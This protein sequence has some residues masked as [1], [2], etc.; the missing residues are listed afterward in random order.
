MIKE[1][2]HPLFWSLPPSLSATHLTSLALDLDHDSGEGERREGAEETGEG[3][4][5]GGGEGEVWVYLFNDCVLF[6]VPTS[7][8]LMQKI[9][10][11]FFFS[12]CFTQT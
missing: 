10:V 11:F 3:G 12:N 4:G 7:P 5:E 8:S 2:N 6:G 1:E 9:K